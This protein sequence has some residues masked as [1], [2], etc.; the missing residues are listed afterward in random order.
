[1]KSFIRSFGAGL[2]SSGLIVLAFSLFLY[3]VGEIDLDHVV[4]RQQTSTK[5]VLFCSGINHDFYAYKY[6]IY[7]T[8]Q[9]EAIAIGSSRAMEMRRR[10]FKT[11]F[12]NLGGCVSNVQHLERLVSDIS[13]L[14]N[15]PRL[16]VLFVDFWW[17]ND[18]ISS[19]SG[20]YQAVEY[21]R[22]P[23]LSLFGYAIGAVAAHPNWG[24][25]IPIPNDR[26]GLM[27]ILFNAGFDRFGSFYDIS[28][29]TGEVGSNDVQFKTTESGF[30]KGEGRFVP[31]RYADPRLVSRFALA[32]DR[33][34]SLGIH[35]IVV[36]PPLAPPIC[37][38][39]ARSGRFGYIGD[40]KTQL[41]NRHLSFMDFSDPQTLY[42]GD[43]R[44]EFFDGFHGGDVI[45]ARIAR[46]IAQ[47]NTE[48]RQIIDDDYL[49]RFIR[50]NHGR[51]LGSTEYNE[52]R[53]EVDFLKIGVEK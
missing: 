23:S 2:C 16:A 35:T 25:L 39:V 34:E 14:P 15:R 47:Q 7:R 29:I 31:G 18:R 1:M 20:K 52:G 41:S 46:A 30:E 26:L 33:L 36:F 4:A 8:L 3:R 22:Y 32:L 27:G 17:F 11:S 37:K 51:A 50:E 38:L 40:L 53:R 10:F 12:V 42:S 5:G 6:S 28:T 49:N 24:R 9:P 48:F 43:L 13:V 19:D 45:Y 44:G 21:P